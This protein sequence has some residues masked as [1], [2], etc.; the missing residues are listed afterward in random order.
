MSDGDGEGPFD[1]NIVPQSQAWT[2]HDLR[3]QYERFV[4]ELATKLDIEAGLAD[5][6]RHPPATEEG[7]D[8]A[9]SGA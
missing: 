3:L 8:E 2:D 4:A 1:D 5:A 6:L 9:P 7:L